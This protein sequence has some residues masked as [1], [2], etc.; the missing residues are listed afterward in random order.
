MNIA[1]YV[2]QI[3]Q[4]QKEQDALYSA[5]AVRHGLSNTAQLTIYVI[6]N[7]D[8]CWTQQRLCSE[9]SLPKQT[10]NTAVS[11]LVK[12]G[13]VRLDPIPGARNQKRIALTPSGWALAAA[14]TDPLK[15]AEQR[16]YGRLSDAELQAYLETITKLTDYL[17]QETEQL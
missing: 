6:S 8:E 7:A 12:Q 3:E 4:Q 9:Y 16:A 15:A 10:V 17:R 2:R 1:E 14:I 13:H 5:V 11:T